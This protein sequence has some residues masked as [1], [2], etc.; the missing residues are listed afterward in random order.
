MADE[1]VA[2]VLGH[3]HR[4]ARVVEPHD[5]RVRGHLE[6]EQRVDARADVEDAAQ[7]RLLVDEFLRRRP[8]HGMV[9]LRRAGLPGFDD[10]I[11]EFGLQALDPGVWAVVGEVDGDSHG[12]E[13]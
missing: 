8:H 13:S 9:G 2:H 4:H 7:L 6:L 1:R 5:A 10:G 11:G 12:H 3:L